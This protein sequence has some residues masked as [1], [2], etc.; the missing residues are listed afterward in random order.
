VTCYQLGG[1]RYVPDSGLKDS[2]QLYLA[3]RY[4]GTK[5]SRSSVV[6]HLY[7]GTQYPGSTLNFQAVGKCSFPLPLAILATCPKFLAWLQRRFLVQ[8]GQ[9]GFF[10]H[11]PTLYGGSANPPVLFVGM[12]WVQH[13][14][15]LSKLPVGVGKQQPVMGMIASAIKSHF[16]WITA[17]AGAVAA[18]V[19]QQPTLT[20]DGLVSLSLH[21]DNTAQRHACTSSVLTCPGSTLPQCPLTSGPGVQWTLQDQAPASFNQC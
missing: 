16:F 6:K 15:L 4:T 14:N 17:S 3:L 10:L 1:Q 21:G 19:V 18:M 2:V 12:F 13:F 11:H 20:A 7:R 8:V 9:F 5:V